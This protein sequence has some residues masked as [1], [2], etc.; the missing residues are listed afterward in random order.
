VFSEAAARLAGCVCA[1]LHW[2]PDA[3]WAA[4]PDEVEAILGV[5]CPA[6]DTPPDTNMITR[7]KEIFP[8]G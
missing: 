2:S 8:D 7:L 4:T 3:F 1:L 5:L 6:T